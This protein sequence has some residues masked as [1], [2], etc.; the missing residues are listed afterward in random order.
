MSLLVRY[1]IPF[2]Q[3]SPCFV[4]IKTSS[5][6]ENRDAASKPVYHP[7]VS[8]ECTCNTSVLLGILIP[9]NFPAYNFKISPRIAMNK[10]ALHAVYSTGD[11]VR[12]RNSRSLSVKHLVADWFPRLFNAP[13]LP[14]D[15]V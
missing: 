5:R 10:M 9:A 7:K 13:F 12:V 3:H 14:K 2:Y 8:G 4:F 1:R 15:F 11:D 6:R